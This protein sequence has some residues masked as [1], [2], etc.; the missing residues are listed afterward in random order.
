MGLDLFRWLL[1]EKLESPAFRMN[2]PLWEP[3]PAQHQYI[4]S[5]KREFVSDLESSV[6][7]R[8][9]D[10]LDTTMMPRPNSIYPTRR[11]KM[12]RAFI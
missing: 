10:S 3:A 6:V 1:N 8:F 12:G 11:A 7:G 9:I 4:E 2:I 5:L